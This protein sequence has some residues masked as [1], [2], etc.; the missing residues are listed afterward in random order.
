MS[1]FVQLFTWVVCF[2]LSRILQDTF[3]SKVK[4]SPFNKQTKSS[5]FQ[6]H[7]SY[8]FFFVPSPKADFPYLIL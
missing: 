1:V 8:L 6:Y 5:Y 7:V 2:L 3:K 4:V